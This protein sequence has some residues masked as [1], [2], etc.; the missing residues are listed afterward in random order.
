MRVSS[1]VAAFCARAARLFLDPGEYIEIKES[2]YFNKFLSLDYPDNPLYPV[3][4]H[5]IVYKPALDLNDIPLYSVLLHSSSTQVLVLLYQ[6]C[7]DKDK[8]WVPFP[9]WCNPYV[10]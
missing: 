3:V 6:V 1:I 2:A 5:F 10:S 4:G 9:L 8:G 7:L